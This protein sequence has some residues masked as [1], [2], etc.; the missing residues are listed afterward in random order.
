MLGGCQEFAVSSVKKEDR[1]EA[2]LK[3]VYKTKKY[4]LTTSV[5][6]TGLVR[7]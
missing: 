2:A 5:G 6:S 7:M 1:V 3:A 4:G